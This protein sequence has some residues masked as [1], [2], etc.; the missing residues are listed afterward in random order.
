MIEFDPHLVCVL[1][2]ICF[3]KPITEPGG[4]IDPSECPANCTCFDT[5]VDYSKNNSQILSIRCLGGPDSSFSIS[6][7]QNFTLRAVSIENATFVDVTIKEGAPFI[8]VEMEGLIISGSHILAKLSLVRLSLDSYKFP[9]RLR[10]ITIVDSRFN[11]KFP[12][13]PLADEFLDSFLG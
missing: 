13:G 5:G 12:T 3:G 7:L 10:A 9:R 1:F 8:D 4:I 6:R 11:I 2:L